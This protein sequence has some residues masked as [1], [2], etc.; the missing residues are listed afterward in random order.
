MLLRVASRLGDGRLCA[1]MQGFRVGSQR[2]LKFSASIQPPL[3]LRPQPSAHSSADHLEEMKKHAISKQVNAFPGRL[4][5]LHKA[6]DIFAVVDLEEGEK[7]KGA[8]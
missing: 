4:M 2:R 3:A 8:Q 5:S 1:A 6:E 7:A